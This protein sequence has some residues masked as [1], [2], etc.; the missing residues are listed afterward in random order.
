[1][2]GK[3]KEKVQE[4]VNGLAPFVKSTSAKNVTLISA[5][6]RFNECT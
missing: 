2:A 1:M 5:T 4:N 6:Y 3:T